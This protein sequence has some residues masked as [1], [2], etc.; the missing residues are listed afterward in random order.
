MHARVDAFAWATLHRP[1][2][3]RCL[4]L[5]GAGWLAV[6]MCAGEAWLHLLGGQKLWFF[7]E[8]EGLKE[9]KHIPGLHELTLRVP[10][11]AFY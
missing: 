1:V 8:P 4:T 7:V 10:G 11:V 9:L 6:C 5:S 2:H 3:A